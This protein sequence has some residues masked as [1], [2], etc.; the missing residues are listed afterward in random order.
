MKFAEPLWLLGTLLALL[1]GSLEAAQSY[2]RA[3]MQGRNTKTFF[4]NLRFFHNFEL[5]STFT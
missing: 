3:I 5:Q 4:C 1:L 2:L